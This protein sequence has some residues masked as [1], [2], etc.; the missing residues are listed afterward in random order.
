MKSATNLLVNIWVQI[1]DEQVCTHILLSFILGSLVH[2]DGLSKYFDHIQHFDCLCDR[3]REQLKG[4]A[5]S[6]RL[7]Q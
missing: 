5:R 7:S 6:S 1:A 4:A 2:A 3:A